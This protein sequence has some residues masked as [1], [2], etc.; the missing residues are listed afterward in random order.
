MKNETWA[1]DDPPNVAVIA[2]RSIVFERD[3]IA[4]VS[5]D[6]EDGAWQFHGSQANPMQEVDALVAILQNIVQIDG[7]VR[8]LADLLVGWHAWRTAK[9]MPLFR[10]K[11]EA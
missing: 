4:Y 2:A 3:W 5:H 6:H 1:F 7:T 11:T 10:A 9:G 8:E